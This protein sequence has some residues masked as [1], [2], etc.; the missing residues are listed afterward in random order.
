MDR[1]CS[2]DKVTHRL[3]FVLLHSLS[4]VSPLISGGWTFINIHVQ[5]ETPLMSSCVLIQ[6]SLSSDPLTIE[7]RLLFLNHLLLPF[8]VSGHHSLHDM[9]LSFQS[10]DTHYATRDPILPHFS[11]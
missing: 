1:L 3:L 6:L 9:H 10:E 2:K 4:I 11:G 7:S 5:T 8:L